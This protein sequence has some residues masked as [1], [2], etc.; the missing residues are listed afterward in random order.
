[1]ALGGVWRL[2]ARPFIAPRNLLIVAGLL[3]CFALLS[4]ANIRDDRTHPFSDWVGGFYLTFLVP[5][6]AF[7]SAAGASREDMTSC[8]AD[9]V[10]TRPVNRRLYLALRYISHLACAQVVLLLPYSVLWA[11]GGLRQIP[12]P[13]STLGALL[14]AQMLCAAAFSALGFLCGT[15]TARY[16]V[17]GVIYG[18]IVEAAASTIPTQLNRLAMTHHIKVVLGR[19]PQESPTT[20]AGVLV[21]YSVILVSI[22]ALL[23]SLRELAGARPKE[24]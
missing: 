21:A 4:A 3:T 8:V 10:L 9:Y 23:F 1:L 13:A 16:L 11:V 18:F 5:I 17:V 24:T 22:A 12:Q 6:A 19:L 20:S 14:P 7:L 15:L 2:T